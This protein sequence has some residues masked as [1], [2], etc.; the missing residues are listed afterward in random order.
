[1]AHESIAYFVG[2]T[3]RFLLEAGVDPAKLRFR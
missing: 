3:A 1:M 2:I